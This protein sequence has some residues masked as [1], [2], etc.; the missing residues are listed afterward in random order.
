MLNGW[1]VCVCII[2]PEEIEKYVAI[3]KLKCTFD[4]S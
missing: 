1:F 3:D 4:I 2:W